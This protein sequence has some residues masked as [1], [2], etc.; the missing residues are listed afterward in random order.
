MKSEEMFL[1]RFVVV[2]LMIIAVIALR[3]NVYCPHTHTRTVFV[4][5]KLK[6]DTQFVQ[7]FVPTSSND[8]LLCYRL[9]IS[10]VMK[11]MC[12]SM[13]TMVLCWLVPVVQNIVIIIIIIIGRT[14][15]YK[16]EFVRHNENWNRHLCHTHTPHMHAYTAYEWQIQNKTNIS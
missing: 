16:C 2:S 13:A 4:F 10:V 11:H 3:A 14:N 6:H 8:E 9:N 5:S 15:Q 12:C 1:L 7:L